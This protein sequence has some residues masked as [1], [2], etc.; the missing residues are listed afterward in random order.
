MVDFV[1]VVTQDGKN[2]ALTLTFGG[3]GNQMTYLGAGTGTVDPTEASTGLSQ[4]ITGEDY[5]RVSL[6]TILP[7]D[8]GG[9]NKKVICEGTFDVDNITT[10]RTISELGIFNA[11]TGGEAFCICRIPNT[12]KDSS[13]K[14]KFTITNSVA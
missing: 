3:T 11:L 4:E 6:D 10:S 13:K 8:P 12:T 14:V 9:V 5:T 7:G 2:L 1:S